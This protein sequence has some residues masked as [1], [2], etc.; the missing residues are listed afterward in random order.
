MLLECGCFPGGTQQ[1]GV[2]GAAAAHARTPA[3]M[4]GADRSWLC[5][6]RGCCPPHCPHGE[7]IFPV[8]SQIPRVDCC[9]CLTSAFPLLKEGEGHGKPFAKS[10]GLFCSPGTCRWGK[11]RA[12]EMQVAPGANC[13]QQIS[14]EGAEGSVSRMSQLFK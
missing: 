8:A 2:E 14:L 5:S 12:G 11:G 1:L 4:A 3:E 7:I 6:C 9:H 10:W 13:M